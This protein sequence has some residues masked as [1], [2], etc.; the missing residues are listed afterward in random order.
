MSLKRMPLSRL[1]LPALAAG[2][3]LLQ[4]GCGLFGPQGKT[5][6]ITLAPKVKMRLVYVEPLKIYVGKYEVS[7]R[8]FRCFRPGHS[9]GSHE[10]LSLDGDNQPVVN[11]S[12]KDANEFCGWLNANYATTTGRRL[13]FR[14]PTEAEWQTYATCG[15]DSDFPWGAWPPPRNWNYYGRENRSTGQML[16]SYDGHRVSCDVRKSGENDWNLFGVGGNVW[17][18]CQ[19]TES[20]QGTDRVFKGASWSDCHPQFLATTRRNS[21]SPDYKYVNLGFRVVADVS[22]LP[23]SAPVQSAV[24]NDQ[25]AEPAPGG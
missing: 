22:E 21:Y 14:L 12:W 2:L 19:D 23:P 13:S 24:T 10:N 17:E 15:T 25:P 18:W 4:A 6:S 5:V 3:L 20:A 16:D 9:S 7:N 11:V 8:E 1:A